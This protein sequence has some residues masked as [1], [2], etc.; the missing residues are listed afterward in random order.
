MH[1]ARAVHISEAIATESRAV[2]NSIALYKYNLHFRW[3]SAF[4]W[5]W[6]LLLPSSSPKPP[7][8]PAWCGYHSNC[9][10]SRIYSFQHPIYKTSINVYNK[11][12]V[13]IY[14]YICNVSVCHRRRF[15]FFMCIRRVLCGKQLFVC[16]RAQAMI[17]ETETLHIYT[18]R[19]RNSSQQHPAGSLCMLALNLAQRLWPWLD[20]STYS[21]SFYH[22]SYYTL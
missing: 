13:Q 10:C 6:L 4:G 21:L 15:Q 2:H 9:Y 5:Q 1:D 16:A 17:A 12:H 11:M 19:S 22:H 14:I 20:M 8:P 3:H 18:C 7:P